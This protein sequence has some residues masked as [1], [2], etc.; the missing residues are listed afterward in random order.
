MAFCIYLK[1]F[2][3][4]LCILKFQLIS[5]LLTNNKVINMA[6]LFKYIKIL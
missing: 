1:V 3:L 2:Y 6:L 5:V 4:I